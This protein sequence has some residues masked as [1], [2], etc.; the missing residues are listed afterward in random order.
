MF[1][2]LLQIFY[3]NIKH[4]DGKADKFEAPHPVPA[5]KIY[6]IDLGKVSLN[7]YEYPNDHIYSK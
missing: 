7:M 3:Q 2:T 1:L 5:L 4:R 6:E